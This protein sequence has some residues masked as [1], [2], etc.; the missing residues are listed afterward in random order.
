[1]TDCLLKPYEY[2]QISFGVNIAVFLLRCLWKGGNKTR[3][4]SK[5]LSAAVLAEET[6]F[7]R[8]FEKLSFS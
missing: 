4:D 8:N 7:M 2:C 5:S 3:A 6:I 1:M